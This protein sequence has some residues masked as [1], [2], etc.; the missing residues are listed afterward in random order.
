MEATPSLIEETLPQDKPA[1]SG[2]AVISLEFVA[3]ALLILL[4]LV[5]RFAQLDAVPLTNAEARQA[6]AAWRAVQP[7]VAGSAIVPESP[8]LFA[9]HSLSFSVLGG[10][11]FAARFWTALGGIL[12]ILTPLLFRGLLGRGRSFVLSILLTFSPVLLVASRTDSAVVWTVLVGVLAL[13]ALWRYGDSAQPRYAVFATV[14]LVCA[15]LLTDP[16]GLVFL[17]ILAGAGLFAFWITPRDSE[18]DMLSPAA[19]FTSIA[20]E[21]WQTWPWQV[22]L[23]LAAVVVAL[24]STLFILYPAGLSAVSGLLGAFVRGLTT[25]QPDTPF[26]FPVVISLFYDPVLVLMGLA[27][28]FWLIRRDALTFVER[29]FIGWLIFG[30]LASVAYAGTGPEHA[31]WISVPLAG[32]TSSLIVGL[33]ARS[34]HPLWWDVP[35]WSKWVV[36]IVSVGLL[37]MFSVHIQAFARALIGSPEGTFQLLNSSTASV[38]WVII[39]LLFMIIGFFLASSIWGVNTTMQGAALGLLAFGL[40]TSLGSGWRAAAV[41][42]D[43][44]IELWNRLPISEDV[45]LLRDALYEVADR[46]TNGFP[47]IPVQALVPDDGVVAWELRDFINTQFITDIG[48]A[49]A[50]QVVILPETNPPPNLDSSYVGSKFDVSADWSPQSVQISDW[51]AWWLQRKT[52]VPG[53]PI[54]TLVLWLRQDVY[55]GSPYQP[56]IGG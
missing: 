16:T 11:E 44:P 15:A 47:K 39:S 43:N 2:G 21:R 6:L 5:L 13:W 10:S 25:A 24:V 4:A 41:T 23:L 37:A 26:M 46:Q 45:F 7:D 18:D 55:N 29:F 17:V 3:Y 19:T 9:L 20:R 30:V 33:L 32:L 56:Q 53:T 14:L 36:M 42:A 38:V 52:R 8:L 31:L 51:L 34:E 40:V 12:L 50:Q 54:N 27:A 1:Q 22:G 35:G 28:I 48:D 49:K